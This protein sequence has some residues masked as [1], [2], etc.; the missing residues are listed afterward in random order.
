[1]RKQERKFTSLITL[2]TINYQNL[3]IK[4]WDVGPSTFLVL[5]EQ[6]ARLLN[7]HVNMADGSVRDVIFWPESIDN[8]NLS[9]VHGGIPILF[10]FCG[11]CSHQGEKEIWRAQDGTTYQ[12]PKHGF[13]KDASFRIRSIDQSGFEVE[14]VQEDNFKSFYPYDYTFTVIYH[15][16][17]LSVQISLVLENEGR[18]PIPWSAGLHPYFNIPWRKDLSLGDHLLHLT[19]KRTYQYLENGTLSENPKASYP[20]PL[21]DETLINRVHYQLDTPDVEISLLNGEETL[22]I[23]EASWTGK[24]SRLSYVSWQKPNEPYFCLE[25]WMSP[26]N[27]PENKTMEFVSPGA[28][29]EFTIEINL[30]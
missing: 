3:E 1:M 8:E 15:F 25:P 21:S 24:G 14:M 29:E 27:A 17:E 18:S 7:W 20:V 22:H 11:T 4:R 16:L 30:A 9:K 2:E 26:P 6:G 23:S 12:M 13:A 28:R 10:P 5:P 19:A